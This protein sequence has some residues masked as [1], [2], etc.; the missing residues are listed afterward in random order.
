MPFLTISLIIGPIRQRRL[1]RQH[2][3]F[4]PHILLSSQ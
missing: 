2:L 3:G 1:S 4:V